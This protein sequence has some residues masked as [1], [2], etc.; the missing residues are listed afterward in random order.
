MNYFMTFYS[1]SKKDFL[2]NVKKNLTFEFLSLL[3]QFRELFVCK[4]C[5]FFF[6]RL[7]C[8]FPSDLCKL[9]YTNFEIVLFAL[10]THSHSYTHTRTHSHTYTHILTH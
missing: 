7:F 4:E 3:V 6:N 10:D 1:T 8:T 9:D 2:K 5:S